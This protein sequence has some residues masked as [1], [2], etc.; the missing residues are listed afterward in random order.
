M[1]W[2]RQSLDEAA[3]ALGFMQPRCELRVVVAVRGVG[4]DDDVVGC[5]SGGFAFVLDGEA[6]AGWS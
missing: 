6:W 2:E 4:L 3:F 1:P 5:L